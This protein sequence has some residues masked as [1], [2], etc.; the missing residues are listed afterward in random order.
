MSWVVRFSFSAAVSW[1]W[2]GR[3]HGHLSSWW[4]GPQD[5]LVWLPCYLGL[6]APLR[7]EGWIPGSPC[8]YCWGFWLFRLRGRSWRTGSGRRLGPSLGSASSLCPC[9]PTFT[10]SAG[11]SASWGVGQRHLCFTVHV[12]RLWMEGERQSQLF[13]PPSPQVP[14]LCAESA[15]PV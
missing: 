10:H 3:S 14:V 4:L 7:L 8:C 1:G 15:D 6:W 12:Y 13:A 9:P 5:P 11:F 2:R